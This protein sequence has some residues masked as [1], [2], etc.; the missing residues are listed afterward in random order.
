MNLGSNAPT[1]FASASGVSRSGSTLTKTTCTRSASGPSVFTTPA[2][3]ASV[4]GQTSGQCVKPKKSTTALPRKSSRWRTRPLVSC[5]SIDFPY[6]A[7]VMSVLLN[8][9]APSQAA[10]ARLQIM[11]DQKRG[12]KAGQVGNRVAKG[13][14][15]E[16]IAVVSVDRDR[17]AAEPAAE[18]KRGNEIRHPAHADRIGHQADGEKDQG[19]EQDLQAR[20]LL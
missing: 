18:D 14:L 19:V 9:A 11:I 7:P 4:V 10:S 5:S 15:R 3:S 16:G 8:L 2:R 12:K 20:V 13:L 6:S 1:Y 17:I